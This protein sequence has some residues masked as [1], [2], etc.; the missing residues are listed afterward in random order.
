MKTILV[1]FTI[2]LA[3]PV[4]AQSIFG[5]RFVFKT[6][7]CV[8]RS[9]SGNPNGNVVGNV[10]DTYW[11]TDTGEIY[12]KTSGGG[13]NLGWTTGGVSGSGTPNTVPLWT[14][15]TTLGDSMIS[16]SANDI[17]FNPTGKDVLPNL[18]YDTNFGALTKKYLS[19]HAAE[20]WVETLVAQNTMATIGGRV[21]VAPTTLLTSDLGPGDGVIFVKH[22]NLVLSDRVYLESDGKV[23]FLSITSNSSG[24][25]PYSY[26]VARNLDG[27]GSNQWYAGDAV[28]N[29]GQ[30]GNGFLDLYSVRGT[31]ASTEIGPTIVGNIRNSLTYNDWSPRFAIGN[32]NGL[33]GYSSNTFGAAFGSPTGAR[34]SIEPTGGIRLYDGTGTERVTIGVGGGANATFNGDGNGI[35]N[36]NGGNIQTNTI[37]VGQINATGW[38]DNVI[39]NGTFEGATS[40]IA[41]TGWRSEYPTAGV[42]GGGGQNGPG[43]LRLNPTAGDSRAMTYIATPVQT[44][45]AYRISVMVWADTATAS[46][47]YIRAFESNSTSSAVRYVV[48]GGQT[49][50]TNTVE[51]TTLQDPCSNCAVSQGWQRFTFSYT[52]TSGATWASL[53]LWNLTCS[54]AGATCTDLYFDDVEMQKQIGTGH[55]LANSITA[56]E[57]AANSITAA[58]IQANS[59]TSDKIAANT[60]TADDIAANTIT[61]TQIAANAIDTDELS[62]NAV[63]ADKID[64]SS[65]SAISA[66]IGTVTAGTISGITI[67]AGSGDEVT[68]DDDGILIAAGTGIINALKWDDGSNIASNGDVMSY[69]VDLSGRHDFIGGFRISTF[70]GGG[71]NRFAC[72]DNDGDIY[73]NATTCDGSSPSPLA[74]STKDLEKEVITLRAEIEELRA[75]VQSLLAAK[76][77]EGAR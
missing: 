75:L 19:I 51:L 45:W 31:R 57:I 1:L 53:S 8:L 47:L 33:Y 62:A 70:A 24:T 46:G 20:L 43:T 30:T 59:I 40:A 73:A 42:Y 37:T 15:T 48:T 17:I 76:P 60:I 69:A 66:N 14:G 27:S 23:E 41:L 35:T 22:N 58:K 4:Y 74:R 72:V 11:R 9:G 18:G 77:E 28:L 10:C 39:R 29:T 68:I 34:I 44:G 64:V 16:Q 12:T 52:P 25:G 7:P 38:G 54:T 63:T 32:L 67:I 71:N 36:I 13:T 65:L 2:F 49:L 55:I 6:G 61:G 50:E 21:L 56:N 26:T 5:D 3:S